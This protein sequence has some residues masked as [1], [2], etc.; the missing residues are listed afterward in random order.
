MKIIRGLERTRQ[1]FFVLKSLVPTQSSQDKEK[2]S[3]RSVPIHGLF[4]WVETIALRMV[5]LTTEQGVFNSE[6][7]FAHHMP[8]L[9]VFRSH[10]RIRYG[11]IEDK[12]E[13]IMCQSLQI[14]SDDKHH[15]IHHLLPTKHSN[16]YN[17]RNP[18]FFNIPRCNTMQ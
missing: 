10:W 7:S 9:V 1:F 6:E 16:T 8:G 11:N 2:L 15:K 17:L 3:C 12:K 4:S 18:N 13:R 5:Q 14:N